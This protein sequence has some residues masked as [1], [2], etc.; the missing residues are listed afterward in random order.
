MPS[1]ADRLTV[2]AVNV[3]GSSVMSVTPETVIEPPA[4]MLL[5]RSAVV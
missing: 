3:P 4:V 2:G 5:S 1:D